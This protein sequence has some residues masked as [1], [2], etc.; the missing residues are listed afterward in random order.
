[1]GTSETN[2]AAAESHAGAAPEETGFTD[3]KEDAGFSDGDFGKKERCLT[4]GRQ[5]SAG[6]GADAGEKTERQHVP[7]SQRIGGEALHRHFRSRDRMQSPRENKRDSRPRTNPVLPNRKETG[8][9][10]KKS[11]GRFA[12]NPAERFQEK[13]KALPENRPR[14]KAAYERTEEP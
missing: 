11:R 9:G 13:G 2:G 5:K 12:G 6:Q 4:A 14:G 1:M 10:E 7:R 8:T 3:G